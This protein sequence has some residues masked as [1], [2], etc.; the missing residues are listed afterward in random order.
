MKSILPELIG[1]LILQI[2]QLQDENEMLKE[3]IKRL[4]QELSKKKEDA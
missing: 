2:A 3:Q 4:E 1:Q